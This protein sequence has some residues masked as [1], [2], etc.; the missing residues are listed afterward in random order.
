L[1]SPST[2][3]HLRPYLLASALFGVTAAGLL[4]FLMRSAG[5]FDRRAQLPSQPEML[6]LLLG[7]LFLIFAIAALLVQSSWRQPH[8]GWRR[9]AVVLSLVSVAA[10]VI[11]SQIESASS[12]HFALTVAPYSA[13]ALSI[14][15]LLLALLQWLVGGFSSKS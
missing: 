15:L 5:R 13:I 11:Y 4:L 10:G 1:L 8:E 7:V 9:I 2:S 12:L 3:M 14:S 6:L